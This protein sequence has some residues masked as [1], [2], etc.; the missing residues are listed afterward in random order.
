MQMFRPLHCTR[1][2]WQ[3][4]LNPAGAAAAALSLSQPILSPGYERSLSRVQ[5]VIHG[6]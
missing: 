3:A 2:T 4:D 5:G 6:S 1:R